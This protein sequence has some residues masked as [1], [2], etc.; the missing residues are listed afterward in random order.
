[1]LQAPLPGFSCASTVPPSGKCLRIS[2]WQVTSVLFITLDKYQNSKSN[3]SCNI[4]CFWGIL[5]H[6]QWYWGPLDWSASNLVH[7]IY[8]MYPRNIFQDSSSNNM[9]TMSKELETKLNH[10]LEVSMSLSLCAKF[11]HSVKQIKWYKHVPIIAPLW[12]WSE[13]ACI[14]WV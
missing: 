14:G 12:G 5:E 8:S 6:F 4:I 9:A 3:W 10:A 2:L 13:C 7:S 11:H 1:M